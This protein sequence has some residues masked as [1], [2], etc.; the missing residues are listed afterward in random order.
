M[1][2]AYRFHCNFLKHLQSLRPGKRWVL[3]APDHVHSLEDLFKIYCDADV[4]F[5]HRDPMKVLGSVASLSKLLW[6]AFSREVDPCQVGAEESRILEEKV[7][8]IIEFQERHSSLSGHCIN[9]RYSDLVRD[10]MK[11]VGGIYVHFG[12]NLSVDAERRM[13]DFL[14]SKRNKG[15]LKHIYRIEDFGLDPNR[16]IHRFSDYYKRF[17]VEREPL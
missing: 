5:L 14:E 8:K 1:T 9:I 17:D 7:R 16:E 15:R 6:S 3:K 10:P 11:T 13:R 12:L 4:V 2:P